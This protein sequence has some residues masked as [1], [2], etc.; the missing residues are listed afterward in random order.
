M[1]WEMLLLLVTSC[2]F[3][4]AVLSHC[5]CS[6]LK[7][8]NTAPSPEIARAFNPKPPK[9]EARNLVSSHPNTHTNSKTR[10]ALSTNEGVDEA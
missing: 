7:I 1:L 4:L 5:F 8:Y 3:V 2:I 10:G 9:S 6:D